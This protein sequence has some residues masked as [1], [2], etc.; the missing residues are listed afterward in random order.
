MSTAPPMKFLHLILILHLLLSLIR[1]PDS[2]VG[3]GSCSK[4]R[5]CCLYQTWKVGPF[6]S[7]HDGMVQGSHSEGRN[8]RADGREGV[9]GGHYEALVKDTN[10]DL[11]N[12]HTSQNPMRRPSLVRQMKLRKGI[13]VRRQRESLAFEAVEVMQE[14]ERCRIRGGETRFAR[15]GSKRRHTSLK[16]CCSVVAAKRFSASVHKKTDRLTSSLSFFLVSFVP[17]LTFS[18]SPSSSPHYFSP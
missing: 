13:L 17:L 1:E 16:G 15:G 3:F 6:R 8:E 14:E 2:G 12:R 18:I 4:R 5:D 10:Q 11:D 7:S 9:I